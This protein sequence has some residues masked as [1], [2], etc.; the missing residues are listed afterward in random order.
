MSRPKLA[1]NSDEPHEAHDWSFELRR[2]HWRFCP[3][4][5][6]SRPAVDDWQDFELARRDDGVY[7]CG[8]LP[9]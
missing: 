5:D 1:C 2:R 3:G 9:S 7:W 4:V 6:A 8:P